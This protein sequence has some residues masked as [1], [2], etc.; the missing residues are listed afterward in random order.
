MADTLTIGDTTRDGLLQIVDTNWHD[1]GTNDMRI[2]VRELIGGGDA[3][4]I[5]GMPIERMRRL[6]RRAYPYPDQIAATRIVQRGV[7]SSCGHITF[8]ITRK[9]STL[10]SEASS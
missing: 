10:E 1:G 2:T 6:A 7:W 5:G 9:N 8:L 3:G 4:W